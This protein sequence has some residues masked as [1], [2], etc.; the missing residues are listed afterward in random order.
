MVVSDLQPPSEAITQRPVPIG[1]LWRL[2]IPV[3]LLG[4]LLSL[5]GYFV[6]ESVE[7]ERIQTTFAGDVQNIANSVD[8][9]IDEVIGHLRGIDAFYHGSVSVNRSQ[10]GAFS[11]ALASGS[12]SVQALEWIPRVLH[13]QRAEFEA[14]AVNDGFKNFKFSERTPEGEM[15]RR[16]KKP[17][18]FPVYFLDP[19]AGNEAAVGFDLASNPLR[20][21]ALLDSRNSG[22]PLSTPR[23]TLIQERD[24]QYGF[25]IFWPVYG[26]SKVLADLVKGSAELMTASQREAL[27]R[28][29]A[30]GVFRIGD[31]LKQ[32]LTYLNE[33]SHQVFLFDLS[34][35]EPSQFLASNIDKEPDTPVLDA[36]PSS[37]IDLDYSVSGVSTGLYHLSH[38]QVVDRQWLMV[39]RATPQYIKSQQSGAAIGVLIAGLL[40][41]G[42]SCAQMISRQRI[43]ANQQN[44]HLNLEQ[45]VDLRTS[46]L[47]QATEDLSQSEAL[48]RGMVTQMREGYIVINRQGEI[49]A[50]N[51]AAET[52]FG[53]SAAATMGQSLTMLMPRA[54]RDIHPQYVGGYHAEPGSGATE[55]GGGRDLTGLR[56]DGEPIELNITVSPIELDGKSLIA[57]LVRDVTEERREQREKAA[58]A[59]A[60]ERS[61]TELEQFAYVASH[62]LQEPL[63][64]INSYLQLIRRKYSGELDEQAD[65]WIDYAVEGSNRM[66]TLIQDLLSYSRVASE[67]LELTPTELDEVMLIS[68][69][70]LE[71][72][73]DDK[74]AEVTYDPLPVVMGDLDQLH[75]LMVNL[76]SNALKYADSERRSVVH[77][78]AEQ[79]GD[80]WRIQVSDNGIGIE[81][82]FFV[83]IFTIFQR[84]HG[85]GEYSGTGIGLAICKRIVDHHT[86]RI[87]LTSTPGEGTQ[88][89][90]TLPAFSE[91]EEID[92]D[93]G[94]GGTKGAS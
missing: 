4:S 77:V 16:S 37:A 81:E 15:V 85:R 22:K 3:A 59:E 21:Q 90:F 49:E 44:L 42:M 84:L 13:D 34:D 69:H 55:M 8:R 38:L 68:L 93:I 7:Q 86:G 92:D 60:L 32:S 12:R 94:Y 50:F 65:K 71:G 25:L 56:A 36:D 29:F 18:Y 76:I 51:P 70:D 46:E 83:K 23:I 89:F 75:Q 79:D 72:L 61:N 54:F 48:Y 39:T 62:D 35:E 82:R 73:I 43:L 24:R 33:N 53:Y 10:F 40:I 20:R 41:T 11:R 26:E 6:A 52:I 5:I 9:S 28:G 45:E 14:A 88:F 1:K 91:I 80:R 58:Y 17:E 63:R 31:L 87:W 78:S 74:Q 27:F 47:N 57:G 19:L 66:K 30:L 64:M 67:S 2:L